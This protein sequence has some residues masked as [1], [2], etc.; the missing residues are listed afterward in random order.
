MDHNPSSNNG[1]RW[2][3]SPRAD[4]GMRGTGLWPH[5]DGEAGQAPGSSAE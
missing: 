5:T 2:V 4:D 3:S 1:I